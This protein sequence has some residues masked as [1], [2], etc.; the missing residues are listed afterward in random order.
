MR[1][2]F[3]LVELLIVVIIIAILAAI[4]LPKFADSWRRSTET[5]MR[6]QLKLRRDAIARFR[7][8]TGLYPKVHSDVELS[9]APAKGID[10]SGNIVE[11]PSG[12]WQGPY[13]NNQMYSAD[14]IHS[15]YRGK[16]YTYDTTSPGVG[17]I[18]WN[19]GLNDLNEKAIDSW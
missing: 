10:E 3:T 11:I 1:R 8:D 19:T 9:S 18:R 15:R 7:N 4:A 16:G 12:S 6:A 17:N 14:I 5:R 13:L 2:A